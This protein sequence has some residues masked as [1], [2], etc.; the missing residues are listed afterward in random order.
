M[1][2]EIEECYN[3]VPVVK[4][5]QNNADVLNAFFLDHEKEVEI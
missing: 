5:L 2:P 1:Q 4:H 3:L